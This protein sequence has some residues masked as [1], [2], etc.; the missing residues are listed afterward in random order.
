[1][2]LLLD[3]CAILW[4]FAD[5]PELSPATAQLIE[6]EPEVFLSPASLW[7]IGIK[8]ASGTL[9]GPDD[10]LERIRD[11]EFTELPV[12]HDHVIIASRLPRLHSD[13]FDRLLVAQAMREKLTIIT[14]DGKIGEYEVET[15]QT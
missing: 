10:L 5:A 1:M 3:T 14:D 2:R 15:Q 9:F 4:W 12:R 11:S 8:Q 13:P 6:E 7:E